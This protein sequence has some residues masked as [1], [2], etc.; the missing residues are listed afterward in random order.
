MPAWHHMLQEAPA[1]ENVH[2]FLEVYIVLSGLV[3]S[4]LKRTVTYTIMSRHLSPGVVFF[5]FYR[6]SRLSAISHPQ[7]GKPVARRER[8]TNRPGAGVDVK[9]SCRPVVSTEL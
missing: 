1:G 2:L 8:C 4:A 9:G 6:F 3:T 5:R 7:V